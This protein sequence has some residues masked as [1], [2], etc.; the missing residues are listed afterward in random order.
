MLN[1]GELFGE[2]S[3]L[4]RAPRSATVTAS[5]D[6]YMLEMLRNVLETMNRDAGFKSRLDQLYRERV[7]RLQLRN[8]PM[9]LELDERLLERLRQSAE[10]VEVPSGALLFDEHEQSDALHLIRGGIVK[11]MQDASFL[12]GE[13]DVTDWASLSAE[14]SAGSDPSSGVKHQVWKLLPGTAQKRF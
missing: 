8:L 13:A 11:V 12:I 1:E 3:C 10:L 7:L 2:M 6:C 9:L 4:Y 5:R 14:L